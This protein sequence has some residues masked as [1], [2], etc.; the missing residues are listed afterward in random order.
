MKPLSIL[1][2]L[3]PFVFY[4]LL[5]VFLILYLQKIDIHTLTSVS[6]NYWLLAISG[7]V[8]LLFRFWGA[9][10][11]V[12]LLR[13]LSTRHIP[14]S[15]DLIDVYA[16]S[17][18]GRYLPASAGWVVGKIYFASKHGISKNIL[19]INTLLEA[20]VQIIIQLIIALIILG[21][22]PHL[23]SI[24]S[25]PILIGILVGVVV[26]ST[27]LTP[28]VF[29]KLLR[30]AYK[31]VRHTSSDQNIITRPIM[32]TAIAFYIATTIFDG[33]WLYLVA[34]AINPSLGIEHLLF[35][36]GITAAA[37]AMSIIAIF[38]PGGIGVK[39][40]IQLVLFSTL[41]ST[42][43]ALAVTILNRLWS[44]AIDMAFYIL[45]R[46]NKLYKRRSQ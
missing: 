25:G 2:K 46:I 3:V 14:Y 10:I 43:L 42:E 23:Y 9:Y 19:T 20:A 18:L 30:I 27:C 41:M 1:K 4:T 37:N 15:A 36:I 45:T 33:I 24:L 44:L 21:F 26:L 16:K 31:I 13:L 5:V 28:T 35:V 32:A 11:W 12:S 8:G 17:W 29:N 38:A 6:I 40:G 39:D 34:L 22:N 7:I